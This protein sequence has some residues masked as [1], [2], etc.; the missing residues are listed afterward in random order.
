LC[1]AWIVEDQIWPYVEFK[2]K[3]VITQKVPTGFREAVATI[4]EQLHAGDDTK[5]SDLVIVRFDLLVT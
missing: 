3:F 4:E 1:S 2:S 5:T